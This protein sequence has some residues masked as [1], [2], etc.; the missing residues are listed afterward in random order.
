MSGDWRDLSVSNLQLVKVHETGDHTEDNIAGE[1]SETTS[2]SPP[3]NTNEEAT[4]EDSANNGD[5]L[6]FMFF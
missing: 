3:N 1:E 6:D 4:T 5:L 2:N